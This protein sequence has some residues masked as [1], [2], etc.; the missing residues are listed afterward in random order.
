MS[1][2]LLIAVVLSLALAGYALSAIPAAAFAALVGVLL[3]AGLQRR[4]WLRTTQ[5]EIRVRE[6]REAT[7]LVRDIAKIFDARIAAQRLY[8]RNIGSDSHDALKSQYTSALKEYMGNYNDVRYRLMSY[9]SYATVLEFEETLNNRI[10][11]NS[12]LITEAERTSSSSQEKIRKA[13]DDLSVVS[14]H[15]FRFCARMHKEIGKENIGTLR[16]LKNW[17]DPANPYVTNWA[18]VKRLLNI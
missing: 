6:T 17:Q 2:P 11:Q 5:E 7:E 1:G 15:V 3:T 12:A 10:V 13:D 16:S 9:H 4:H 8:L 14:A 18:L